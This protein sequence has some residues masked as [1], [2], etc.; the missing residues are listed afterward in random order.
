MKTFLTT[1]IVARTFFPHL[2]QPHAVACVDAV[3][4]QPEF[5]ARIPAGA[6]P[7]WIV[8]LEPAVGTVGDKIASP[9]CAPLRMAEILALQK[10]HRKLA[11]RLA[12]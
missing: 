5:G 9:P 1:E 12:R 2:C 4:A 8:D 11:G 6:V 10:K 3:L 7:C